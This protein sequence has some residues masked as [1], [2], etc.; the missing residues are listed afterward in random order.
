LHVNLDVGASESMDR[1]DSM[2]EG[3]RPNS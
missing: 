2:E 3:A 1:E